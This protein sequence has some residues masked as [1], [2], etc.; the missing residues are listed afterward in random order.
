MDISDD[1]TM[2][3]NVVVRW[4]LVFAEVVCAVKVREPISYI[5]HRKFT[6]RQM[7]KVSIG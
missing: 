3:K 4:T 5:N 1:I 6:I 2:E 7:Y